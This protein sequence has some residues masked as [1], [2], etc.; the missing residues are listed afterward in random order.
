VTTD[1]GEWATRYLEA[2]RTGA[3]LPRPGPRAG[4]VRQLVKWR[5]ALADPPAEVPT[6]EECRLAADMAR[7]TA[8]L[9]AAGA[10]GHGSG[11]ADRAVAL[12]LAANDPDLRAWMPPRPGQVGHRVDDLRWDER[13]DPGGEPRR[14]LVIDWDFFCVVREDPDDPL[15][16]LYRW[17]HW[18]GDG[19]LLAEDIWPVRA[20]AFVRVGAPL[21]ATSGDERGFW[22]RF[23][24]A[25]DAELYLADSNAQ[26]AHPRVAEPRPTEV[27]LYDAHHDA[28]Y[29]AGALEEVREEGRVTCEDWMLAYH[30]WGAELHVRYPP[31]RRHAFQLDPPPQVALL[32]RQVATPGNGP[33]G[34]VH[35]VFVCRS[36]VWT[37][38]W[39]DLDLERLVLAAPVRRI[40]PL[41]GVECRPRAWAPRHRVTP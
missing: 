7:R 24:I 22:D 30:L 39:L 27:W 19:T 28:G 31:W 35:A 10:F 17:T 9:V 15:R 4:V 3:P 11:D 13:A 40:V 33:P 37:P 2:K 36:P 23:T 41:Q 21:P 34:P 20:A 12:L 32:D 26:A 1:V 38:P 16:E 25:P 8:R 29:R 5:A 6:E 14:L 18:E